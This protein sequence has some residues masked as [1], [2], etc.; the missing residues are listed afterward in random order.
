MKQLSMEHVRK[1]WN[2]GWN[3]AV[4]WGTIRTDSQMLSKGLSLGSIRC[5]WFIGW[6]TRDIVIVESVRNKH[7][8]EV[9]EAVLSLFLF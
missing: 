9:R 7:L 2:K 1:V 8:F 4:T 5:Y 6:K 3:E